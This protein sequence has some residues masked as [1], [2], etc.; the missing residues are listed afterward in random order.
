M[1]DL[2]TDEFGLAA[3]LGM[4]ESRTGSTGSVRAA[5]RSHIGFL[6]LWPFLFLVLDPTADAARLATNLGV[7]LALWARIRLRLMVTRRAALLTLRNGLGACC[8]VWPP[9]GAAA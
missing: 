7:Q 1:L 6:R 4:Q 3:R 5:F 9:D 2:G 8:R